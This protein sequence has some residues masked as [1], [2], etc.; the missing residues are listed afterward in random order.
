MEAEI[1][2]LLIAR[3][4]SYGLALVEGSGGVLKRGTVYVTLDRMEEKGLVESRE[5]ETPSDGYIGMRRRLYRVTGAGAR[6]LQALELG[7]AILDGAELG[8]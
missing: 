5:E 1:L 7:Q 6:A 2:R 8:T 4:E 3:R